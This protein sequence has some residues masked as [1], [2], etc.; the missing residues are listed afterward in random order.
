MKLIVLGSN[1]SGRFTISR[2]YKGLERIDNPLPVETGNDELAQVVYAEI[3]NHI[4]HFEPDGEYI[5]DL[6]LA[7]KAAQTYTECA[8]NGE[9]FAVYEIT[10]PFE[11]P[12]AKD[13]FLGYDVLMRRSE[14][15]IAYIFGSNMELLPWQKDAHKIFKERLNYSL[16]FSNIE[17]AFDFYKVAK[18]TDKN[19]VL[20]IVGLYK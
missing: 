4:N 5:S 20:S 10:Y 19:K 2:N 6:S 15:L 1:Y 12:K 7:E 14:S 16:L 8:G 3:Q 13:N 17:V 9:K 18:E 11:P